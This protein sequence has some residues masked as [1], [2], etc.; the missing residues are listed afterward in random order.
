MAAGLGGDL[1]YGSG[2]YSVDAIAPK[3]CPDGTAEW[4]A[5]VKAFMVALGGN[6]DDT[7]LGTPAPS[8]YR[9]PPRPA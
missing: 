7:R 6:P 3:Y 1:Y 2:L 4:V 8:P 9:P 5:N